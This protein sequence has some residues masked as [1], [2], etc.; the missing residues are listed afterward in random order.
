MVGMQL[1]LGADPDFTMCLHS[2]SIPVK[3]GQGANYSQYENAEVDKLLEQ[4][5]VEMDKE[6]RIKIYG[7][8]QEIFAEEV[9]FAPIFDWTDFIGMNKDLVGFK[10]NMYISD[11][12]WNV[13]DWD[14]A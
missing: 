8:I 14:W 1:P 9:P 2:K 12:T 11:A 13:Q 10:T 5:V 7:R 4:G 6:K 3:T